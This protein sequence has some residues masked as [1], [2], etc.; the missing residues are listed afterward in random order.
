MAKYMNESPKNEVL[1]ELASLKVLNRDT[2]SRGPGNGE[3]AMHMEIGYHEFL[4]LLATIAVLKNANPYV[5]APT[6]APR[7]CLRQL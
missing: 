6:H 2:A 7:V 4:E 5:D 1:A 3:L